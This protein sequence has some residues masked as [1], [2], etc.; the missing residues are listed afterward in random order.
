MALRIRIRPF[1]DL[2]KRPLRAPLLWV[3]LCV[4]LAAPCGC[5]KREPS[6]G[7]AVTPAPAPPS[8]ERAGTPAPPPPSGE[9]AV[10]PTP[11]RAPAGWPPLGPPRPVGRGVQVREV[12]LGQGPFHNPDG[13]FLGVYSVALILL[14][15]E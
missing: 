2:G 11:P 14:E 10:T 12:A 9:P 3:G 15:L 1:S 6:G 7:P 13:S 8:G 5:G 4:L